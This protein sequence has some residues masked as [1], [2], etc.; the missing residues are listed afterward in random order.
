M[1]FCDSGGDGVVVDSVDSAG[2]CGVDGSDDQ[3]LR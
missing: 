2:K 1:W 3:E